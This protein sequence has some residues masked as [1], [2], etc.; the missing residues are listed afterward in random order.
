[1]KGGH[2][3]LWASTTRE[4]KEKGTESEKSFGPKASILIGHNKLMC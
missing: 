1:M 3:P 2:L 4:W